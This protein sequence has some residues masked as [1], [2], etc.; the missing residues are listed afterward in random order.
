MSVATN[1]SKRRAQQNVN[2]F[3]MNSIWIWAIAP[4]ITVTRTRTAQAQSQA[5]SAKRYR[6]RARTQDATHVCRAAPLC[7]S[8]T[9]EI[10]GLIGASATE[11]AREQLF[12]LSLYAL[13]VALSCLCLFVARLN[14]S[15]ATA[16]LALRASLYYRQLTSH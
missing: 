5:Q 15:T 13:A 4:G 7:S 8:K 10:A 6:T 11:R 2:L 9:S 16:A 12:L 14:G 3:S 1:C